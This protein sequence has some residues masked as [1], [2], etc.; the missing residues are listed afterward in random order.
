MFVSKVCVFYETIID[1]VSIFQ[2]EVPYEYHGG[3]IGNKGQSIR[4]LMDRYGVNIEVPKT[5]R[6]LNTIKVISI[7]SENSSSH[8]LR[9][10]SGHVGQKI[11]LLIF[12]STTPF[13][14]SVPYVFIN[15]VKVY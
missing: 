10:D 7:F 13:C 8:F 15:I 5:E 2:V 1:F 9:I 14:I 3:I 6:E 12:I 11:C 4:D